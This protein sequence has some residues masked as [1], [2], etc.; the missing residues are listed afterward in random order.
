MVDPQVDGSYTLVQQSC[1]YVVVSFSSVHTLDTYAHCQKTCPFASLEV[2]SWWY[3]FA[4]QK[5]TSKMIR[6]SKSAT[7]G[8]PYSIVFHQRLQ[9][10]DY[11][12]F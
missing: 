4:A 2:Q 11:P 8:N 6:Q 5:S 1:K 3:T 7:L 10:W 12:G 9:E